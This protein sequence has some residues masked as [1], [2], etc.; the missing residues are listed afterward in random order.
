MARTGR[1]AK[2]VESHLRE[3][4]IPHTKAGWTTPLVLGGRERPV[5]SDS[6]DEASRYEFDR[7]VD[8]LW[9]SNILDK[10]DRAMI[11]LA[12]ITLAEVAALTADIEARGRIVK[13]RRGGQNGGKIH[14]VHEANPAVAMRTA[15]MNHARQLLRELG[16]GPS[17]RAGLAGQGV[18]GKAPSAAVPGMDD[19]AKKREQMKA[20]RGA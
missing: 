2:P 11:E 18:K 17:A 9:E 1:P 4:T 19:I 12:A 15:A 3:G 13:Q 16:I 7:L 6:L 20:A 10:A 14:M 8:E 5:A